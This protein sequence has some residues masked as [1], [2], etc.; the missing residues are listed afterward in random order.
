MINLIDVGFSKGLCQPWITCYNAIDELM[1]I[2][3]FLDDNFGGKVHAHKSVIFDVE[4]TGTFYEYQK[5]QCSS[6]FEI[7]PI[8]ANEVLLGF[9]NNKNLNRYE[10]KKEHSLEFI[11]LD[12]LIN[13]TQIKFDFLKSDTQGSD[14]NVV[15]SMGEELKRLTGIHIELYYKQFYK[16]AILFDEADKFLQSQGFVKVKSLRLKPNSVFDDFLYLNTSPPDSDKLNLIKHVY[17]V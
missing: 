11:R 8:I 17:G 15:L 16:D 9:A 3:P 4:K 12:T 6:V 14:F 2:D 7:D 10:L 13:R 5:E 1:I